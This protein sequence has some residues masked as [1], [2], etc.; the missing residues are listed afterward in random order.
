MFT[1][2]CGEGVMGWW[3]LGGNVLCAVLGIF[4][5]ASGFMNPQFVY[6]GGTRCGGR[7]G[8]SHTD[9]FRPC[10]PGM[11]GFSDPMTGLCLW[12]ST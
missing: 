9:D 3:R 10:L 11:S 8:W 7:G 2:F 12:S 4:S 1:V 5:T 6:Y